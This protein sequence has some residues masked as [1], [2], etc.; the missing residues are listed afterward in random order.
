[1]FLAR[2]QEAEVRVRL[3]VRWVSIQVQAP[4]GLS[5]SILALLLQGKR[6]LPLLIE[7]ADCLP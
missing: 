3:R 1:M 6:R 4:G 5:L 2:F 7:R